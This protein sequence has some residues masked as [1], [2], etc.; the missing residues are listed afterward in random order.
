LVEGF[1]L[2]HAVPASHV[3]VPVPDR[4]AKVETIQR[5]A[6]RP[7]AQPHNRLLRDVLAN[8]LLC[9]QSVGPWPTYYYLMP[10]NA[11]VVFCFRS[12]RFSLIHTSSCCCGLLLVVS[13]ST[14]LVL[15][16]VPEMR[17]EST[18]TR[19]RAGAY[20]TF[21]GLPAG[22]RRGHEDYILVGTLGPCDYT[23]DGRT[24]RIVANR[25][26]LWHRKPRNPRN[27]HRTTQVEVETR[28]KIVA[29]DDDHKPPLTHDLVSIVT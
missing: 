8:P 7:T 22:L 27:H 23:R 19:A 26:A 20:S 25:P 15:L 18:L 13:F 28:C 21:S 4:V 5:I 6:R 1:R 24:K 10:G 29:I 2:T 11:A 12:E 17:R 14:R 16:L 9:W 3:H